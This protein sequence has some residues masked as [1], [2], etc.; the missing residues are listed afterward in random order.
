M[1]RMRMLKYLDFELGALLKEQHDVESQYINL[2]FEGVN[3]LDEGE[4]WAC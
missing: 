3:Y 1:S 2:V 4:C